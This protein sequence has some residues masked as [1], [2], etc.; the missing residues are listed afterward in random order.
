MNLPDSQI[1]LLIGLLVVA[2]PLVALGRR[3][4]VSYP[5]VLVLG[6]L[7]LGFIPGLPPIRLDP[8]L[9]LLIF[10]PPLLYWEA[11]T[12]PT[13]IMLANAGQIWMLAIGLVVAT[14]LAVAVVVHAIIPDLPWAV[15][16]VLG[17]IVAPTDELAAVPVLERFR[18][19]RHVIAIVDGESL[20]NDAT[21]LV[22]YATA[23]TAMAAAS[24]SVMQTALQFV[25]VAVGS[26]VIGLVFGRLAVEGWRRIRDTQLQGVISVVLPFLAYVPAQRLQLSGVLAVVV[27]GVY[28]NRF[29]PIVITPKAR[30]RGIGFWENFVFLAN[31]VLFLLVG[32]QL[33]S[34]ASATF[35]VNSWTVVLRDAA[36]VNVVLIVVRFAWV[37]GI[38]Y[39]PVIGGSSEHP[40]GDWKHA[41]IVAWSGLRGAVSLA[42][43]LAIPIAVS[44]VQFPHRDLIIFITFTVILVTLV[45]GGLTL[46]LLI[47]SLKLEDEE[48]EETGERQSA[49]GLAAA[50]ALRRIDE[51][52]RDGTIDEKHAGALRKR[53]EHRRELNREAED[54]A[55]TEHLRQHVGAEREVLSAQRNALIAMRERGEIDNAVL[56]DL[57]LRL[58]LE[59]AKLSLDA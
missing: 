45:G 39:L 1:V 14:T 55:G 5:V 58:D 8:N 19:P 36:I 29:T 16:F 25:V 12:A 42:A 2:I 44:G 49:L 59:D 27:A 4:N 23:L 13:D 26:I 56:R 11:I 43:A 30:I 22:I 9:V 31:A 34:V 10:L 40:N 37:L 52:E 57:Q 3:F 17:A 21:A 53:Y 38:E 51:L 15:A 18:L 6:G 41:L 24:F 32:L 33:H 20:L 46:P 7:V 28:V 47:Q 54:R 48:E 50:A 35:A